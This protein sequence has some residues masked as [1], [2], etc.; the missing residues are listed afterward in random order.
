MLDAEV[1][2]ELS[3]SLFLEINEICNSLE[4][5]ST[6]REKLAAAMM[7]FASYQ[8]LVIPP[9]PQHDLSGLRL[10]PGVTGELKQEILRIARS[11][12]ELRSELFGLLQDTESDVLWQSLLTSY[13]KSYWRL[14]T[15]NAARVELGDLT[16]ERDWYAAFKHASCASAEAKYRRE[17]GLPSAFDPQIAAIAPTAYAIYTDIVLSG[18]GDPDREWRDYHAGSNIPAPRESPVIAADQPD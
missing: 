17:S 11:T 5:V 10:L 2:D 8:V 7:T 6:C 4:P 18:A 15:F 12:P 9:L 1:R 14:E 13:W 3:R 16:E